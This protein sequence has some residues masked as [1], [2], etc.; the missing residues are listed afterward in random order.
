[1]LSS[2]SEITTETIEDTEI[3][4]DKQDVSEA[5]ASSAPEITITPAI[6]TPTQY[7]KSQQLDTPA[8][9][10]YPAA[11]N[12]VITANIDLNTGKIYY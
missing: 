6:E 11:P 8:S 5:M 7:L 3:T 12:Q 4:Q 10:V 1:V 2:T 9:N